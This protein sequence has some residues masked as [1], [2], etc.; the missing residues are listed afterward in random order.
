MPDSEIN[1]DPQELLDELL[2]VAQ[3]DGIVSSD[4][5]NLIKT[6]E[7]EMAKYQN[8]LK[9]ANEDG[10]I[11]KGEKLKL[12]GM[13]LNVVRKAFDTVQKDMQVTKDEQDL[14]DAL[15]AKLNK[16]QDFEE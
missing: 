15:M 3:S 9:K 5:K 2:E 7:K 6:V 10:V 8:L 1:F 14:L 11:D 4:E 16:L 12:F 13:R